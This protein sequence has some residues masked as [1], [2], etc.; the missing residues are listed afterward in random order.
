[1]S[2]SLS[3]AR[4][5]TTSPAQPAAIWMQDLMDIRSWFEWASEANVILLLGDNEK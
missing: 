2:T 4:A 5:K 3:V 1:M